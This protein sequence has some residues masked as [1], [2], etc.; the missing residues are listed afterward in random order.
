[1]PGCHKMDCYPVQEYGIC[2]CM[3]VRTCASVQ[4]HSLREILSN[5]YDRDALA[6]MQPPDP[7]VPIRLATFNRHRSLLFSVAHRMLV[8][9]ADSEYMLQET[10][11]RCQQAP[12]DE[13]RSPRAF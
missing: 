5:R 8:G 9:V 2:L 1:M 7:E 4:L 11:T 3:R 12:D 10:F 13:S 6:Q